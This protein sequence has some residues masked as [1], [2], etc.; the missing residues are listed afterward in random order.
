MAT[1]QLE[2]KPPDPVNSSKRARGEEDVEVFDL[3]K[4]VEDSFKA[5]LL[6]MANPNNWQGFRRSKERLKIGEE[7]IKIS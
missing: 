7:D 6:S 4:P 2:E 5:K 3:R 1:D